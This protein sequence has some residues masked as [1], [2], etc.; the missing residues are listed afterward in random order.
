[1]TDSI[2][3]SLISHRIYSETRNVYSRWLL[4]AIESAFVFLPRW[5]HNYT[6]YMI[7][8]LHLGMAQVHIEITRQ[9]QQMC[10]FPA[11]R[12]FPCLSKNW[13]FLSPLLKRKPIWSL[14]LFLS[15]LPNSNYWIINS[16]CEHPRTHHNEKALIETKDKTHVCP[17]CKVLWWET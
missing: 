14:F 4:E 11:C 8:D 6:A 10:A 3:Y 16:K 17:V 2:T 12:F 1:M 7:S 15:P 13:L 5:F 9:P